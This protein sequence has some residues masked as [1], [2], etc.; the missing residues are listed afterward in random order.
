[1]AGGSA[2]RIDNGGARKFFSDVNAVP[3]SAN[4]RRRDPIAA[5]IHRVFS[6]SPPR[7]DRRSPFQ[8]WVERLRVSTLAA[9][10]LRGVGALLTLS[11]RVQ[12][13]LD[14]LRRHNANPGHKR[15]GE[16]DVG[17]EQVRRI[18]GA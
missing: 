2:G 18:A 9:F 6:E 7:R 11:R 4:R 1:V 17:R 5:D 8:R 12:R 16:P 3:P 14:D 13:T 15:V 10:Y